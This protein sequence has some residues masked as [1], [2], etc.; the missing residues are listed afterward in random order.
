MCINA[1]LANEY[2]FK[3]LTFLFSKFKEEIDKAKRKDYMHSIVAAI[4][5]FK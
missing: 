2:L 1:E 5:A 3:A 4:K